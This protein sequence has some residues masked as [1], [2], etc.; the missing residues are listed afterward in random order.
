MYHSHVA[1]RTAT[2]HT[3]T[4]RTATK[5]TAIKHTATQ[6]VSPQNG[7]EQNAATNHGTTKHRY[8]TYYDTKRTKNETYHAIVKKKTTISL[9]TTSYSKPNQT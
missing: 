5:R 3:A 9:R 7:S 6:S 1:L 4:K 2:Q 8:K